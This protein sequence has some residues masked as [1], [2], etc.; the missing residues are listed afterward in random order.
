MS[1]RQYDPLWRGLHWGMALIVVALLV[2]IEVKGYLPKGPAK[3]LLM[4]A[5]KQL[6][7]LVFLLFWWRLTWR[8]THRAPPITPTPSRLMT[9]L[10]HGAHALLYAAMLFIPVLGILFQQARGNAVYFLG[11]TLPWILNDDSALQYAKTLKELHETLGNAAIW[12]I[13]L[14][15]AAAL[16]HHVVRRDDTLRR[17]AGSWVRSL[18]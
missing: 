15:G 17:M 10:S 8:V 2:A 11:W 3:N 14:H 16:Y 7:V 4:D 9:G 5:H 18:P 13:A 6:G 1:N 12:L